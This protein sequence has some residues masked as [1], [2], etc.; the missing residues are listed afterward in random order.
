M[1]K[2]KT[3]SALVALLVGILFIFVGG[4]LTG[5][6]LMLGADDS[7]NLV[8]T[9]MLYGGIGLAVL[10]LII[11]IGGIVAGKSGSKKS[12]IDKKSD[13][14]ISVGAAEAMPDAEMSL[15][16]ATSYNGVQTAY[17]PNMEAYEFVTVGRRQSVEEKFEQIGKMSKTQF[18]VYVLKLLSLKGFKVVLTPVIDNNG[19]DL[20]VTRDGITRG[21]ACMLSNKVLSKED[22][23]VAHQGESYY[24]VDGS[25]VITNMF[26]DRSALEYAK[27][28]KMTLIDRNILIEQYMR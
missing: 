25:M 5:L 9:I 24:D 12:K 10:G 2:K 4:A 22:I 27:S 8:Y 28:H 26:F 18:V 11:L 6:S 3:N 20:L 23:I 17:M 21:A 19:I 15:D 14:D 13:A 16:G 1:S 7:E